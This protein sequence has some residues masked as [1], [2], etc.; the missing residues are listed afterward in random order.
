MRI[1]PKSHKKMTRKELKQDKF[2][3]TVAE[4]LSFTET[5]RRWVT[6]GL[7]SGLGAI[8]L[9][10]LLF[11][12]RKVAETQSEAAFEAEHRVAA[13]ATSQDK[14][15]HNAV[16]K[17]YEEMLQFTARKGLA[18]RVHLA[19]GHECY[20]L[21]RYEDAVNHFRELERNYPNSPYVAM[22]QVNI[23]HNLE[24]LGQYEGAEAAYRSCME[25]D[26]TSAFETECQLGIGRCQEAL[27][28]TKE[29]IQSYQTVSV[30]AKDTYW[31]R[32]ASDRVV[33]LDTH[34]DATFQQDL[35]KEQVA[36]PQTPAPPTPSGTSG[37][38]A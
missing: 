30:K 1:E 4:V 17:R 31:G 22:A 23:G 11:W 16:L 37:S 25:T 35:P 10:G 34:P 9:I 14:D 33:Y 2:V 21:G 27:G 28:K 3:E 12:S 7:T 24:A 32:W 6:W 8:V 20:E 19:A 26:K 13:Q 38:G 5:H 29:A 36:E 15:A 18:P